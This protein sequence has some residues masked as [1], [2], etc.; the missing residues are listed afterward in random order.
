MNAKNNMENLLS[1]LKTFRSD[2][3]Y[4]NL[5]EESGELCKSVGGD[6]NFPQERQRR[7]KWHFSYKSGDEPVT[8]PRD[9]FD[10]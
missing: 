6:I 8:Q 9:K 5:L 4:N 3:Q 7:I 1:Y 2:Q 10:Y